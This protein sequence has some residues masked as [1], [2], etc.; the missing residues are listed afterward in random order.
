VRRAAG[1][2]AARAGL[3]GALGLSAWLLVPRDV[4]S[5]LAAAADGASEVPAGVEDPRRAWQNWTLNCQGCHRVDGTGSDTTAPSLA[6]TVAKFLW[7][8]GGREYLIRVPGVATSAL[9]DAELAEVMN[10]MFWRFDR[11]HLPATFKPFTAAQIGALR[12]RPL[13]LEASSMRS[14]LLARAEAQG[15]PR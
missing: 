3:A 2:A 7:V 11:A 14:A 5:D 10:W 15:P 13:R 6:G 9:P 12:G 8:P 1:T 4:P